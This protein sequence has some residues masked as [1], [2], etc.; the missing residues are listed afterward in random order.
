MKSLKNILLAL[1]LSLAFNSCNLNKV[2]DEY[3]GVVIFC[4]NED[5]ITDEEVQSRFDELN[6]YTTETT[7]KGY[8]YYG[9]TY[10]PIETWFDREAKKYGEQID[11]SLTLYQKQVKVPK[12][13]IDY[14][15]EYP[16]CIREFSA[17]MRNENKDLKDYYFISFLYSDDKAWEETTHPI[18]VGY[19]NLRSRSFFVRNSYTLGSEFYDGLAR[20]NHIFAHEFA[21]LL[22]A[23]DKYGNN[24]TD[25]MY[26]DMDIMKYYGNKFDEDI[27]ISEPTAEELGWL[28]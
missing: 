8:D 22:G 20:N 4:Y 19:A 15:T 16:V 11:I 14:S 10:E 18:N 25:D 13:F 2:N 23:H 3:N 12:K 7:Y 28:E 21:H 17:Y 6:N 1:G 24:D 5:K 26:N 9:L 27:I